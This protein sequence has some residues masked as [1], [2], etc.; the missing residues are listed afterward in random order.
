MITIVIRK[1]ILT[2]LTLMLIRERF[3]VK[4][5]VEDEAIHSTKHERWFED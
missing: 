3:L 1:F 4:K 2:M 5:K